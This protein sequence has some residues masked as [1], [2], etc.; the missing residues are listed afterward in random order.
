MGPTEQEKQQPHEA[1]QKTDGQKE[2]LCSFQEVQEKVNKALLRAE[3]ET[4]LL[5][6]VCRFL[7]QVPFIK[8]CWIARREEEGFK[9]RPAAYASPDDSLVTEILETSCNSAFGLEPVEVALKTGAPVIIDDLETDP[10]Y[11]SL[12][13]TGLDLS[14]AS[15]MAVPL[16]QGNDVICAL[17]VYSVKKRVF[18][19]REKAFLTGV[20]EDTAVRITSLRL[21]RQ[22]EQKIISLTECIDQTVE[23]LTRVFEMRDPYTAGHQQR[24]A[25]LACA[26]AG[27]MGLSAIQ[28]EGIRFAGLLHDVGKIVVPTD[29]LTKPGKIT[30]AEFGLIKDHSKAGA[31]IVGQINFP[32]PVKTAILQHHERLDGSGYPEGLKEESII[33]EARILAVADIVDAIVS[34]RPYRPSLGIE[35]ALK[36]IVID[37]GTAF[38]ANVVD[39]CVKI[40]KEKKITLNDQEEPFIA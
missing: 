29:I 6:Q 3:D 35:K 34:H 22:L 15:S 16:K 23:T 12:R 9:V 31:E 14:I 25:R 24:T 8:F 32:Y 11:Q 30:A 17:S 1:R 19:P 10:S 4:D 13:Q 5:E 37:R 28:I 38:D 33:L 39:A 27:E 40:F 36:E 2:E 20:A 7:I 18:G 21:V 26:I